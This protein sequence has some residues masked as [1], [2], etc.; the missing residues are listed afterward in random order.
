M[1]DADES[2]PHAGSEATAGSSPS[3][4][5]SPPPQPD[6]S[7]DPAAA[8]EEAYDPETGEINWDCPCMEG[9]TKE[10]CGDKFKAAFSCFVYSTQEPKGVDCLDAFR[11]MQK[12]FRDHPEQYGAELDD[13]DDDDDDDDGDEGDEKD[14]DDAKEE[15]HGK[16][17][18]T[19][20]V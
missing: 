15:D 1:S 3:S 14:E 20:Y 4:A 19:V 17:R 6:P 16:E 13:D 5:S 8:Q 10:P 2:H 11:E 18:K 7:L 9:M 12:C